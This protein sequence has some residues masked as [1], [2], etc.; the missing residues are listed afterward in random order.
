[1]KMLEIE[2]LYVDSCSSDLFPS[3]DYQWG[4]TTIH[5]NRDFNLAKDPPLDL[6]LTNS[7]V[8]QTF[9][10]GDVGASFETEDFYIDLK[11]YKLMRIHLYKNHHD[12]SGMEVEF[13]A[14]EAQGYPTVMH[15][16]GTRELKQEFGYAVT[17]S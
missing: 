7:P 15:L 8:Y 13:D 2:D 9:A 10:E 17:Y 11:V 14:Y 4:L 6:V 1:M 12:I 16:F 3:M 5:D